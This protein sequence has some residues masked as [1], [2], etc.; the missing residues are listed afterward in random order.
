[1]TKTLFSDIEQ[2]AV[3]SNIEGSLV[4]LSK[5]G[6]AQ[7]KTQKDFLST[8]KKHQN[9][10]EKSKH[11]DELL[12][13]ASKIYSEEITPEYKKQDAL[14]KEKFDVMYDIYITDKLNL[15]G[16]IKESFR[17]MLLSICDENMQ[18]LEYSSFY[19]NVMLKLETPNEKSEREY[20][21][22]G[23]ERELKEKLGVDV[24]MEDFMGADF[25]DEATKE[26]LKEKYQDFFDKQQESFENDTD[27]DFDF[28]NP[29]GFKNKGSTR[30]K[31]TKQL[32]KEKKDKEVEDLLNKDINKLFKELAKTIHPDREQD[33]IIRDKK[34]NLMKLL[35]N[36][37]DNMNIGEI[38][39][40]KLLIDD[41][42][43]DNT[44]DTT[45]N[46][47]SIKRFVKII[48][49]KISDIERLSMTKLFNHP[50]FNGLNYRYVQQIIAKLDKN[51]LRN[52]MKENILS[53]QKE[54]KKMH[55]E[56]ENLKNHPKSVKELVKNFQ[57]Y[58]DSFEDENFSDFFNSFGFR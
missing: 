37:R 4:W 47:D 22:K 12:A 20:E 48:K 53:T 38:L 54:T 31:T 43:P 57:K 30:K 35:S 21:T 49:Q 6:K 3:S 27:E 41:L 34:E 55:D 42:V 44:V 14:E 23:A 13:E 25:N 24:D 56:I 7:S 40:I 29:F 39:Y 16:R 28:D 33:P 51:T 32:E 10:I 50:L 26:R 8:L 2:D 45:F 46:D 19:Y 1:M 11:I 15:K 9:T 58:N 5:G 52:E 17:E 36:A 18:D